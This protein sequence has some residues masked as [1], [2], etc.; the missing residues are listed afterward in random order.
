MQKFVFSALAMLALATIGCGA[1]KTEK[2][3]VI[4]PNET[5][6][7]IPLEGETK[8]G[9]AKFDSVEFLEA[10][11]VATKRIT[12][13][14]RE[15]STGRMWW[16]YD[17]IDTVA[18]IKVDRTPIT[19]EWTGQREAGTHAEGLHVESVDSI[20]FTFGVTTTTSI[21]E[22]DSSKFL[23]N[24]GSKNL[25]EVTDSN[26]RSFLLGKLS[27]AC[28]NMPLADILKQKAQIFAE[29]VKEAKPYF[30]ERGVS[31]DFCGMAEG[32]TFDNPKI[33]EAIDNK[34]VTE[35]AKQV[36]INEKLA[37]DERNK[38]AI[39]KA[40]AEA[41]AEADGQE[42]KNKML[43]AKANAEAEAAK[44]FLEAKEGMVLK[45]ELEVKRILAEA[46]KTAAEKWKGNSPSGIVPEGSGFLFGLDKLMASS[47]VEAT[48]KR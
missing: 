13:S 46:A 38:M 16:D 4:K 48:E 19:R 31:I 47:E 14:Q 45:T 33:Q 34:F 42:I 40:K 35:N 15:K 8:A 12:I 37:Q 29:A 11:K 5:A 25:G 10:K 44:K 30:K 2:F 3:E 36:A 39:E 27:T 43:I 26:V 18:I 7:V 6:Y 20:G 28:G 23:Y 22:E 32:L 1:Y 21:P 41:S 9:Q 17:W 24:Y